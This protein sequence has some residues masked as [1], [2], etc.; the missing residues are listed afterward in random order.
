MAGGPNDAGVP[1][2]ASIYGKQPGQ[3]DVLSL[4]TEGLDTEQLA[5]LIQMHKDRLMVEQDAQRKAQ[6][7][8]RLA[9]LQPQAPQDAGARTSYAAA[10]PTPSPEPLP[11]PAQPVAK[12]AAATGADPLAAL[13]AAQRG[14]QPLVIQPKKVTLGF[15]QTT[16]V[17]GRKQDTAYLKSLDDAA[18]ARI[19]T[20]QKFLKSWDTIRQK[21]HDVLTGLVAQQKKWAET[22]GKRGDAVWK[23]YQDSVREMAADRAALKGF[24]IDPQRFSNNMPTLAK[25]MWAIAAAGYGVAHGAS[26]GKIKNPVPQMIDKAISRDIDA[27]KMRY[28]VLLNNMKISQDQRNHLWKQWNVF[29]DRQQAAAAALVKVQLADIQLSVTD[30]K[31][32]RDVADMISKIGDTQRTARHKEFVAAQPKVTKVSGGRQVLALPKVVQPK[33]AGTTSTPPERKDFGVK[34]E[35]LRAMDQVKKSYLKFKPGMAKS[36]LGSE[37]ARKFE[38]DRERALADYVKSISGAQVTD[39]ERARLAKQ[40]AKSWELSDIIQGDK[41]KLRSNLYRQNQ[42]IQRARRQVLDALRGNP[43]LLRMLT[44]QDAALLRA[45]QRALGRTK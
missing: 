40:L 6:L 27:Q 45:Q 42:M 20:Q 7:Q 4:P 15:G 29:A 12:T 23:S 37:D 13:L 11:A 21:H 22:A 43:A 2:D 44:P 31:A 17:P 16:T 39:K 14:A 38:A 41:V 8:A 30:L 35:A 25:V 3:P 19:A 10:G 26:G 34:L 5:K 9:Q 24:K 1:T 18:K 33:G 28:Q 36:A 32:K